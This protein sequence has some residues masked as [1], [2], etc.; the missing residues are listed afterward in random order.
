MDAYANSIKQIERNYTDTLYILI[1]YIFTYILFYVRKYQY[2]RIIYFSNENSR[3]K[4]RE[5]VGDGKERVC[6][7]DR[8]FSKMNP[9]ICL[10]ASRALPA[11]SSVA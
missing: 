6:T 8:A 3:T 10:K 9:S 11:F 2:R 5:K 7:V 4:R 1:L